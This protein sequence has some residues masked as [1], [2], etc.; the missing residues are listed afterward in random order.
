M[1]REGKSTAGDFRI[2]SGCAVSSVFSRSG[3]RL[4]GS[5]IIRSIEIMHDRSNGLGGGFAGYGIYP[6][7]A[8]Q[9]AFHVFYNN[10]KAKEECEKFINEH[11]DVVNL[12]KIPDPQD[13]ADHGRAAYLAVLRN[14]AAHKACGKPA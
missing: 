12:S 6:E 13:S 5:D 8:E 9:Y 7:Y 2:P 1:L 4:D 3:K 14:T 11:F 10:V